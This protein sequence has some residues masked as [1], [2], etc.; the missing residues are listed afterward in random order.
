ME[1][2]G[3]ITHLL[4]AGVVILTLM[5]LVD[6][7]RARLAASE[8]RRKKR[9]ALEG[10]VDAPEAPGPKGLPLLGSLHLLSGYEVPYEAFGVIGRQFGPVASLAL[11]SVKCVVVNG[12][13]AVR[14]VLLGPKGGHFDGRPDFRRYHQL[15]CG[16]KENSLAFCNW[17]DVQKLRRDML[18][19]HTFPRAFSARF[20]VLDT[21]LANEMQSLLR[22]I[23]T[24]STNTTANNNNTTNKRSR[25]FDN[26]SKL[27]LGVAALLRRSL[28]G[29]SALTT[30]HDED[31]GPK[32]QSEAPARAP[33]A[34]K[35]LIL[36]AVANVF[37]S[38]F[39]GKRFAE[40]GADPAFARMV[41]DFDAIF[42][43]VN[44]GYAADFLP[45]LLPLH[46]RHLAK[47]SAWSHRIRGF[48]MD[49]LVGG[50]T[51]QWEARQAAGEEAEETDYVGAL[52]GHV[53]SGAEPRMS[54]DT[55]L[56]ALE[57]IIGGHS[58]VGNLLI[59]VL[60]FVSTR[61][62]VQTRVR[63][64]MRQALGG[65]KR[66]LRL[67]DRTNMPYTEAIVFE[68][69]RLISSPIVPHVANKDSTIGGY[70]VEKDTLIFL[71]NYDLNMS[72]ELWDEPEAFKPE[73]FLVKDAGSEGQLRL[74]KPEHFLPFGAGR[75]SCMGY[76][77]VQYVSFIVLGTVLEQYNL[78]PVPGEDYSVKIGNLALPEDTY[79]FIFE[80]VR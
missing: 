25:A 21:I 65:E 68:A 32:A 29:P 55:A 39:A 57:D 70:R 74:K 71:N 75:R 5:C 2:A 73:R 54:W 7:L 52:V 37:T 3:N 80:K 36:Q 51:E 40:D 44:Q 42:H 53:R 48:M 59:K 77:L 4:M 46:G 10:G 72:S 49:A 47:L 78:V 28:S 11:G 1:L 34:A 20:H 31:E 15:F 12:A 27:A 6:A 43:E 69:I 41:T 60:A 22:R 50:R 33:A 8:E 17:S 35:P 58:A 62:E 66:P 79:K 23:E 19:G 76:K 13:E 63:A 16:D 56:F 26:A 38:Y 9:K 30:T 18:K 24:A 67:S 45:W 64:E 14:E 61:P